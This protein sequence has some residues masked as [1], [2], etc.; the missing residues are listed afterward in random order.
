MKIYIGADHRGFT[1]KEKLKPWLKD[2]GYEVVDCGGSQYDKNDDFPDITFLVADS[3]AA[4]SGSRGIVICGSGGGATF[5]ANKVCGIRCIT[6]NNVEDVKHN[7]DHNDANVL[8]VGSDHTLESD[9]RRM[10]EAFL[11]TPFGKE[12]RFLRRLKKVADREEGS[13]KQSA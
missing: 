4:D 3:I 5:A 2:E 7:R 11:V 10:I 8:A 6:A 13:R 12:E 9:I 1:M